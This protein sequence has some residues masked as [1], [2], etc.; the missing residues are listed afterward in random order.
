[1]ALR[2]A[3]SVLVVLL[4]SV[5]GM[6]SFISYPLSLLFN[7]HTIQDATSCYSGVFS[8]IVCQASPCHFS[9]CL[10][11]LSNTSLWFPFTLNSAT[12][13][14]QCGQKIQVMVSPTNAVWGQKVTVTCNTTCTLT[15]NHTYIWYMNGQRLSSSSKS[16][17][18]STSYHSTSYSCAVK[19]FE[20]LLSPAVCEC[21]FNYSTFF[22]SKIPQCKDT[23][24]DNLSQCL[25]TVP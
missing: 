24:T 13:A 25:F 16:T 8:G 22:K 19:G 20:D 15:D 2:T 5:A 21:G 7:Q 3:G 23:T 4:L 1:M 18:S 12:T 6:G 10:S 14:T 11:H 9:S 17:L